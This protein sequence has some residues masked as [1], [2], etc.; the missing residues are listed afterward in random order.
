M[1]ASAK[2]GY[3][4]SSLDD[5]PQNMQPLFES[6]LTGIP[7]PEGDPDAPL[8]ALIFDSFFDS[9][10]GVVALIRVVD[11]A[12]DAMGLLLGLCGTCMLLLLL[13][14]LACMTLGGFV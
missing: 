7:A 5:E 10:R 3:A 1:F 11:S 14:I 12:A 9:Y 8:R 2:G 13:A 6:I 4:L